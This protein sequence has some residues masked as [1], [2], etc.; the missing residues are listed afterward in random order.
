MSNI[1]E[2]LRDDDEYYSGIGRQYLSNSDIG[3]LLK[4]PKEYGHSRA[5]SSV[6]AMGRYFHQLFLEPKKAAEV[7]HLDV[8]TRGTKAYKEYLVEH[9]QE[10]VLLTKEIYAVN[11]WVEAMNNN[12]DF[13]DAIN[14]DDNVFEQP[15]IG[16]IC[17]EMWKG[18]ADIVGKDFI[19]DLKTTSS[20]DDFKWNARKYNYDSQAYI[21]S[22]LFNKPMVFLVIDKTTLMMGKYT[23]SE[24]SLESG[25]E[26]V[27]RAVEI[28]RKFYGD[29]PTLDIGQF[30][31]EDEI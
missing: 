31:F 14:D 11:R 17:G 9:Q 1:I 18:K 2:Q 12:L 22:T 19:Y 10:F 27:K 4:N 21:Y 28:Y 20:I 8:S 6:F 30:Y 15:A 29:N 3:T 25:A 23:M 24:K 16:E 13:F 5:D 26:K 7:V